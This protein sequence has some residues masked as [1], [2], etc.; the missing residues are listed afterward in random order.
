MGHLFSNIL[1][2]VTNNKAIHYGEGAEE[3]D[4]DEG[5]GSTSKGI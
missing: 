4:R 1:S 3:K 2:F 5:E